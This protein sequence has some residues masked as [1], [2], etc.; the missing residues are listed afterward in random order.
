MRGPVRLDLHVH[1]VHSPDSRLSLEEI[2]RQLPARGLC[3]FALT[4]HNT[5]GGHAELSALAARHP[6]LLFLPGVEVST[7]EGHLLAYGVGTLPPA[8]R[9]VQETIAWVH[10]Q[11]G[12]CVL[13]HPFRRFHGVGRAIAEIAPVPA[14]ESR[15]GHT[16]RTTNAKAESVAARRGLGTTGG[17]DAHSPSDL[18]RA[19][20]EFP[21]SP[22]TGDELLEALRAGRT[23][24][25]GRSLEGTARLRV[26]LGNAARFLRRGMR[27]I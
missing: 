21:G 18:G 11:G 24:A 1:S 25:L 20:T 4:D 13:A 8:H 27:P 26:A 9:P 22:S 5:L 14:L 19:Y 12:V 16:A 10:A 7:Y 23:R 6:E 15:N 17:S 2:V 3:G